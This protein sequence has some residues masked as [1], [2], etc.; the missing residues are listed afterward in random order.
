MTRKV[1]PVQVLAACARNVKEA[2]GIN[3]ASERRS[4]DFHPSVW[5]DYFIEYVSTDS[6]VRKIPVL[7][8]AWI[9]RSTWEYSSEL[10]YVHFD[11]TNVNILLGGGKKQKK[12]HPSLS[13]CNN[14]ESH[15][16]FTN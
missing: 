4:V 9:L 8:Y 6:R 16:Q 7:S 2:E 12:S 11:P 1:F 5:G 15:T 14:K 3:N 13:K 10:F